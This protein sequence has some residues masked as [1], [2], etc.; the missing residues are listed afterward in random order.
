MSSSWQIFALAPRKIFLQSG[1]DTLV[2]EPYFAADRKQFFAGA[3]LKFVL[4]HD[5]LR[6]VLFEGAVE[7][8]V[9]R[10]LFEP[11]DALVRKG[12]H[13]GITRAR[14]TQQRRRRQKFGAGKR[15][16]L[17]GALQSVPLRRIIKNAPRPQRQKE[18]VCLF[19]Q[20]EKPPRLRD[21]RS[22]RKAGK[23]LLSP[24]EHGISGSRAQYFIEL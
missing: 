5:L 11:H 6:D 12:A 1:A 9:L 20:I 2:E 21:I 8:E 22:G 17:F 14:R 10:Q 4:P 3:V 18:K 7:D 23:P 24:L 13:G 15:R 19:G 16:A